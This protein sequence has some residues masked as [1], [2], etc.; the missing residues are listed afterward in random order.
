MVEEVLL[1]RTARGPRPNMEEEREGGSSSSSS[2]WRL[3][4]QQQT[5]L[6]RDQ[7]PLR[8]TQQDVGGKAARTVRPEGSFSWGLALWV[9]EVD[10]GGQ[11]SRQQ[12]VGTGEL[13]KGSPRRQEGYIAKI[14]SKN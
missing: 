9:S 2:P 14:K 4:Q 6:R 7:H 13:Y 1:R 5:P 10:S 11:V 3:R 8:Q 12:L